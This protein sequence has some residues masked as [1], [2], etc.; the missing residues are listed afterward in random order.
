M[1]N[2]FETCILSGVCVIVITRPAEDY[3]YKE[4]NRI[5]GCIDLLSKMGITVIE[6][7]KIHQKLAIADMR[8]VWYGSI[9]LLSFGSAEESIMRLDS[10]V[11]AS[12]L[13]SMMR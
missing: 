12:E 13:S 5:F 11:I 4:R 1:M 9:N 7:S 10:A 8:V 2:T 6:K 3:A